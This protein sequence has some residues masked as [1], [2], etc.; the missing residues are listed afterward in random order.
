MIKDNFYR[1]FGI[2]AGLIT[3]AVFLFAGEIYRKV[4][5]RIDDMEIFENS[6][7]KD[8]TF[9]SK[10]QQIEADGISAYMLEEHS[11]PI[12]SIDFSFK[13][14]GY[15]HED[16]D[17]LG[18][19]GIFTDMLTDGAGEYDAQAFKEVCEEYG[20][21][22]GFSPEIDSISGYMHTPRQNLDIALKILNL[23]FQN[24]RFDNEL[25]ALR[26][27]QQITTIKMRAEDPRAE[28]KD[29]FAE[30]IFDGHPYARPTLGNVDTIS[31][32]TSEN[33]RQYMSKHFSQENIVIGIA[34]DITVE[35]AKSILRD[36]FTNLPG[37]FGGTLL[38][39]ADIAFKGLEYNIERPS[40]QSISAFAANGTH[41]SNPDYYHLYLANYIFGGSGLNSRISKLIREQEGLTYGIYTVLSEMD[42]IAMISGSYSSTPQNFRR[43]QQLLLDQWELMGE[44]GV[45]ENELAQA[46]EALISSYN[47]RFATISGIAEMLT[48]MQ[49]YNLGLDFLE[50]RNDYIR[51][52]T[53]QEVN[54]AAKKYFKNMPD[55]VNIGIEIKEEN[56]VW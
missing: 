11:V 30:N 32:L 38:P 25:L 41:R 6:A 14:S 27:Q 54:E 13:N 21:K 49:M 12:V 34:G 37:K 50:K 44:Q 17:K 28:L 43:A 48:N 35:E 2:W 4:N 39:E 3:I 9:N 8:K 40:A 33:L 18:L 47:L 7:F 29:K 55:F 20:L 24:P 52:V 56:N 45:T 10:P 36:V 53:L 22:V 19:V 23:I 5:H 31:N 42:A 26:K 46:K 1:I 51:N 15:A 16:E